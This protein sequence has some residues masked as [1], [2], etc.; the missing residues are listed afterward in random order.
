MNRIL[1][2]S[3][4]NPYN[5]LSLHVLFT[6][7]K[8]RPFFSRVVFVSNSV[9]K[10][11]DQETIR[12]FCDRILIRKNIGFDFG[13][14][15]DTLLEEGWS[16]L[17]TYESLT[18][19]N[20]TCFGP[21][22][23]M[24]TVFD[25]ME[26]P[27]IDFWGLTIHRSSKTGMPGSYLAIPEH[28]QSYF[29]SFNKNVVIS[30]FFQDF[31]NKMVFIKHVDYVINQYETKLTG[32]LV[33][34]GFRYKVFIDTRSLSYKEDNLSIFRPDVLISMGNPFVKVK[35]FLFFK[36]PRYLKKLIEE[37]SDYPVSIIDD[38]LNKTYNPNISLKILNKNIINCVSDEKP[39]K[40][41]PMVA[42]HLHVFYID[43]LNKIISHFINSGLSIDLFITTDTLKKKK[44]IETFLQ[45]QNKGYC[46]K[47]IIICENRGRNIFPWLNISE[48]LKKY[49]V[50]GHFQTI[51][52]I[53]TDEWFG[54]SWME[55]IIESLL[56]PMNEIIDLFKRDNNI[57]IVVPDI[58][59]CYK[60]M[61][62][63][64][65]WGGNKAIIKR[66][67]LQMKCRRPLNINE[68]A[69]PIMPYGS[70][71]WYR[72][73]ALRPL[74][75][76]KLS[77]TDFPCEPL[78][79]DGTIAHAIERLPVYIAWSQ[80]YDFRIAVNKNSILS[81]FEF[82]CEDTKIERILK[83]IYNSYTWGIRLMFTWL[84]WKIKSWF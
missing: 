63:V 27:G 54:D 30:S 83:S 29:L 5:E 72:P 4:Y 47:E 55:D 9:L 26:I 18:L 57:G 73:E 19:M 8:I 1:I 62:Q 39:E 3:F 71:F 78:P 36:H 14:W 6:L 64:Y 15:K 23:D 35:S 33:H 79:I 80:G 40:N 74:F 81:G 31:W 32:L 38:H 58:P 25:T 69:I 56:A 70:M 17:K 7:R 68:L 75:D 50:V 52:I 2:F 44:Q 67:W 53:Y 60:L 10:K 20:D 84:P 24:Q 28:I 51:K 49:D 66:M 42:I 22:Y 59:F 11:N 13:A 12:Q 37:H 41:I 46:L 61:P 43:T 16:S 82:R 45:E 77:V 65:T 48:K 21:I 34:S 76:L